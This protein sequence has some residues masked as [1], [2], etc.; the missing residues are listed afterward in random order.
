MAKKLL[1]IDCDGT[2]T[3]GRFLMNNSGEISTSFHAH[4]GMCLSQLALRPDVVVAIVSGSKHHYINHRAEYLGITEV[5]T[6]IASKKAT[7]QHLQDKYQISPQDTIAIGDDIN[8]IG[9]FEQA[10]TRVAVSN[11][12]PSLKKLATFVT[13]AAGGYGAVREAV[14]IFIPTESQSYVAQ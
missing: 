13:S 7:A 5:H 9:L 12:T 6:G 4:D 2:M 3:D 14:D 1:L 10:H 8:D 11:A